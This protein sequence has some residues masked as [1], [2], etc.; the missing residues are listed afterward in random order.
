MY[1]HDNNLRRM[2]KLNKCMIHMYDTCAQNQNDEVFFLTKK[3]IKYTMNLKERNHPT[4][5]LE[6]ADAATN[7]LI[8]TKSHER[9]H[10]TYNQFHKWRLEQHA[11]GADEKIFLASFFEKVST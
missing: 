3:Y 10:R 2:R 8:P 7:S 9:Y 6:A 4:C 11:E 1:M 5:I